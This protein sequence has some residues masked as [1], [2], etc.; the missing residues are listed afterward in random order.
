[1]I[2][3]LE[4]FLYNYGYLAVFIGTFLEGEIFLFV[5]G[6]FIKHEFLQPLPTLVFSILG[7]L[8]HELIYFFI[9]RWKGRAFLLGNRYTKRRYRKAKRLIEKYGVLSLFIIRFL[10]GMRI[11]PMMLMG[12]TG[13]S[14]YKFL[15]FNLVSLVIWAV[16]F[17][18]IG[19]MF[20]HAAEILFGKIKDVYFV[21]GVAVII[22]GLLVYAMYYFKN[23]NSCRRENE[24]FD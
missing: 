10:Y 13:F 15:F 22:I 23:K 17:L 18:S 12:A 8:S 1:M 16:L 24:R 11:V 4:Q 9:G 6:F 14:L 21:I 19:Y 20:G 2:E 3:N 7:A 5:A